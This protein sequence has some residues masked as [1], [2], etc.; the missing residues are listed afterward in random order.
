MSLELLAMSCLSESGILHAL[1][2]T[3]CIGLLLMAHGSQLT[4]QGL[5]LFAC[6]FFSRFL[7]KPNPPLLRNFRH[8][9]FSAFTP[10][11][12]LI[13]VLHVFAINKN[14]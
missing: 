14:S 11:G 13:A 10:S 8:E 6:G 7:V 5:L 12:F 4:P 9:T 1:W 2:K 3:A